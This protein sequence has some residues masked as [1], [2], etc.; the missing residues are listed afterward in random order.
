M[1]QN[2]Y[3]IYSKLIKFNMYLFENNLFLQ[4][5]HTC[6]L[7]KSNIILE[8]GGG[9]RKSYYTTAMQLESIEDVLVNKNT[10]KIYVVEYE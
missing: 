4:V 2:L 1:L 5:H 3:A 9:G 10:T 7:F 8:W 6:L